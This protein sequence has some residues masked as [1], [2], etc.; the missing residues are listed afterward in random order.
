MAKAPKV[1]L[2]SPRSRST[3]LP[4]TS[5]Y[6]PVK[7]F[8]EG[9]GYDVKGEV[10]G[11]DLVGLKGD[12]P[13]IVVIGELK[14]TFSLELV[15]QAVDRAAA[16]DEVWLAAC[17]S[18]RGKGRETDTRFRNLCRRLGFG[19]LGVAADGQIQLLVSPAA[20]VPRRNPQRRS[21]LVE[22]HKRRQG[23][24][25]AGGG[26]R[27]PIM[28]AYRQ[29][30]LACAAALAEGPLRPRDLKVVAPDAPAI[31]LRNVYGWFARM[32]R[33]VYALSEPGRV[34][35]LQWLQRQSRS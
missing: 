2:P 14:L 19:M 30:A 9:L 8:L 33:G 29:R 11:C 5:L 12:D 28:T 31:L 25:V 35:L 17:L 6:P 7:S 18:A 10:A 15:L 20:P 34:A 32:E 27:A 26:S 23:D 1:R 21:R 24:P 22:E 3:R 13:P 4:E 16:G